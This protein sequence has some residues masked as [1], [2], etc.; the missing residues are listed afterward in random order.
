MTL[1]GTQSYYVTNRCL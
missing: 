1:S